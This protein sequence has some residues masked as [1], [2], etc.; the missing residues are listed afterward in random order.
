MT[1]FNNTKKTLTKDAKQYIWL[2]LIRGI[3]ALAVFSGHLRVI[4]IKDTP[5]SDL[6]ILGK[7]VFFFTGFSHL[8]VMIFFVLSGFLIIKS[9][10]QSF[11]NGKFKI[12]NYLIAR[13]SRLWTV[14]FPCLI[15]GWI[16]DRFGLAYLSDT[17]FYS[18]E[19]KYFY[20]N[21]LASRLSFEYFLGNLFFL[22]N[23]LVPTFGS[24]DATWTLANEFWYYITFPLIYLASFLKMKIVFRAALLILAIGILFFVGEKIA[25]YFIV[26]LFGGISYIMTKHATE[27]LLQ[28]KILKIVL[29]TTFIMFIVL[30]RSKQ[31]PL[32][33]N[34]YSLSF[35]FAILIPFLVQPNFNNLL[36]RKIS[37]YLSNISYTLYLSHLPFIYFITSIAR[38]QEQPWE[39][40]TFL[41]YIAFAILTLLYS[42]LL[43]YIFERNTE[44]IKKFILSMVHS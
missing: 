10:D 7:V 26:W 41:V 33:F 29:S 43:W 16:F 8:A 24:N 23:I 15:L 14:L 34:Y 20:H 27:S 42:T 19:S 5:V 21:D 31:Y 25:L 17:L 35:F 32:I 2:D 6:D 11:Q 36:A 9:I 38:F 18:N 22:Q 3:A 39:K 44:R 4:C 30:L 12:N 37:I 13:V 1:Y 40:K 28:N